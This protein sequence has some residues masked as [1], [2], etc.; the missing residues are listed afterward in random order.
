MLPDGVD[1][2]LDEG[3]LVGDGEDVLARDAGRGQR[4]DLVATA[5]IWGPIQFEKIKNLLKSCQK[6]DKN[7]KKPVV[8]A[9]LLFKLDFREDFPEDFSP[10]E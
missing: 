9:Y 5:G 1:D 3:A 8:D 10:I 4:V 6:S 2:G 7:Q